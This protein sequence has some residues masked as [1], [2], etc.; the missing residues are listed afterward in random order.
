MPK[1]E[2]ATKTNKG[3]YLC[4]FSIHGLI[5]G[6]ELELGRD[7][8]TGG[9]TKY[10]VELARA[11]AARPDVARVDLLT[12]LVDSAD[13]S[14]DYS[15]P[16]EQIADHCNIVRIKAG[17]AG[18]I[19]KEQLW[20]H[21]DSFVDNAID[22]LQAE[23][24]LPDILHS[25]YADGGYVGSRIAHVLGIPLIHTGHS[26][27]RVKRRRLLASG[28]NAAEVESRYNM[29]RRV[30]A[31]ETTLASAE[32]VITSTSQE[33][34]EQYEL[35]DFYQPKQM[36][37]IPPGTDLT[38]FHPP[39]GKEWQTDIAGEISRFLKEPEKP[40]ILALSRPDTRKNIA[41]LV[42]AYGQDKTLQEAAN[43]VVVAG[44][45]DDIRDLDAGAQEVLSE[46]LRLI[47]LYDLY[48]LV[49]YPK[50]HKADDV[51]LIYRLDCFLRRRLRQ[52]CAD[53]AI[54]PHPDRGGGQRSAHR[55]HRGRRSARYHLQ[56]RQRR[57]DQ[58]AGNRRYSERSERD[59]AR[60]GA[61]ADQI[62]QRP[63]GRARIL[64]LG[65]A[66][67]RTTWRW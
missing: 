27:G 53:R 54:W 12:R 36:V 21:L 67:R 40:I 29:S 14:D 56:L 45:R 42:V 26:L 19:P 6:E 51:P 49:A 15:K 10:V 61:M 47:D 34:E 18:Y 41:S 38:R 64:L 9:Q 66:C 39:L 25:H 1:S 3:L 22:Y 24:Q 20:D 23:T 2:E 11:L 65:G 16:I 44:N 8:D 7:A 43:L 17:P 50:H 35:Y 13:V 46:L 62:Y 33:I 5:R 58:S 48:G 60:L 30:D 28:V 37:V 63:P 31:E 57:A 32:R 52:S 55:C 4:L 59:P